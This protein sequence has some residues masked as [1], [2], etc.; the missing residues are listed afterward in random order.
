MRDRTTAVLI[1][2]GKTDMPRVLKQHVTVSARFTGATHWTIS[3]TSGHVKTRPKN[4]ADSALQLTLYNAQLK[5]YAT[6]SSLIGCVEIR[7]MVR[8]KNVMICNMN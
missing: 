8:E 2:S 6:C 1:E 3:R 7:I 4:D 5:K